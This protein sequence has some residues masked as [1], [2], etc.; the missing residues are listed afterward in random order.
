[1]V[2]AR[3]RELLASTA[4][5]E[6]SEMLKKL[7]IGA[8]ALA[9]C[10]PAGAAFAHDE[11][12]GSFDY[13]WQHARDHEEHADFHQEE[14]YAHALAHAQGFYS[15]GDHAAWHEADRE[16]HQA[17]HQD[18]PNTWHDHYRSRRYYR[19]NYNGYPSNGYYGGSNYY[20]GY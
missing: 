10:I 16:A 4:G 5:R 6:S 17:F 7:A 1:M 19:Q 9:L 14:A 11:G 3:K 20:D 12:Y 15:Y 8:A 2:Q 18:H 13:Y